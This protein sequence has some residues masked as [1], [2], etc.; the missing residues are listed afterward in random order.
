MNADNWAAN[1]NAE[2][3]SLRY[4]TVPLSKLCKTTAAKFCKQLYSPEERF[5]Q[6][7]YRYH[8]Q[9]LN[10]PEEEAW[11]HTLNELQSY[12]SSLI[13]DLDDPHYHTIGFYQHGEYAPIGLYGFRSLEEHPIG[14]K[15]LQNMTETGLI[16]EYPGKLGIAHSYSALNGYRNRVLMKFAFLMIALQALAQQY[17]YIFFF[18][19]DHRL[20]PI[21]KRFGLEFPA[22]LTFPDSKHLVGCYSITP[23]HLLDIQEVARQFGYEVPILPEAL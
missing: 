12:V 13:Q 2:V 22:E 9:I 15:L 16:N 20:G 7:F 1:G 18:M 4:Q 8:H 17:Q 19:S 6:G 21:Y 10:I 14:H 23:E 11:Q 3:Q 5:A